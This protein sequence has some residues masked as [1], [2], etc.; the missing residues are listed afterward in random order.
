MEKFKEFKSLFERYDV[1]EAVIYAHADH[2]GQASSAA[3]N[4]IFGDIEVDFSQSFRPKKIP[5]AFNKKLFVICDLLF[6]EKQIEILLDRGLKVVNLDHHD[7][8]EIN[9]D[10]YHCFNPK[11]IY[12]EE[13]ISTSGLIWKF[14]S[15]SDIDWLLAMGSAGDI[16][17]E[18]VPQLLERISLE[19]PELIKD[20]DLRSIYDS[21]IYEL[22]RVVL[23]SFER[24]REG[25]KL[26]QR[27]IEEDY[28]VLYG[29]KL[30][31]EY[32][33]KQEDIKS[34]LNSPYPQ[35]DSEEY[36]LID[37]TGEENPGSY[38]GHLNLENG[39]E[40]VYVEYSD[41]RLYFRNFFG[42]KDICE[43]AELFGGGGAHSRAGGAYTNK[44]FKVVEKEIRDHFNYQQTSLG[45][46]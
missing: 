6:S 41:G 33:E 44:S 25:F 38:G 18:G 43:L 12:E 16:A 30:Y 31:D 42:D 28:G 9:D 20:T 23:T 19:Y 46:F 8:R 21:K 36:I 24:P 5:K 27:S 22:A 40:R 39:D 15:P 14:F 32:L 29:S 3:L 35:R 34:F 45:D 4:Y 37:S 10:N 11:R 1:D 7:V 13:F 17:V 2:D 26:I